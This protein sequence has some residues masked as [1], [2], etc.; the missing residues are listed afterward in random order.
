[1][2]IADGDDGMIAG[3]C[4]NRGESSPMNTKSRSLIIQNYFPTNPNS[5]EACADNSASLTNMTK[6]CY[7]AAGNRWPNF[8]AVDFYEVWTHLET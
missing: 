5:T 2:Q 1:M 3:S 4:P 7:E 6:T 8:I